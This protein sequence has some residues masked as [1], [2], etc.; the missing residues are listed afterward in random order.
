MFCHLS[1]G[2]PLSRPTLSRT[3]LHDRLSAT[4]QTRRSVEPSFGQEVSNGRFGRWARL[5][6]QA[7][8]LAAVPHSD[9]PIPLGRGAKERP[10][11][12]ELPSDDV[13]WVVPQVFP[14]SPAPTNCL[15]IFL[16]NRPFPY[17]L[18][19]FNPQ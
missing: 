19:L 10:G 6:D 8:G 18:P 15:S 5:K 2:G 13:L 16:E 1:S 17:F 9:A 12:W 11:A 7:R 4:L 3:V 14:A